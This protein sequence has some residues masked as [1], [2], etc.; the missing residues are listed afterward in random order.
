MKNSRG[1][2]NGAIFLCAG[3]LK[4]EDNN[5]KY[6]PGVPES[7]GNRMRNAQHRAFPCYCYKTYR[8]IP[9]TQQ[10]GAG[11][12]HIP[13]AVLHCLIHK[14][15]VQLHFIRQNLYETI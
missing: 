11:R 6:A 2:Q 9:E 4:N 3:K 7:S 10:D 1:Q 5:N 8:A 12:Q 15:G 14:S 13:I